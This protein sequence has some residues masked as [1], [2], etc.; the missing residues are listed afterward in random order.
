MN[1][2]YETLSNDLIEFN[3]LIETNPEKYKYIKY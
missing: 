3:K 2:H 1:Q